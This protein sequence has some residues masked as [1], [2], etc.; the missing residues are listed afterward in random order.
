MGCESKAE[1]KRYNARPI[2]TRK[3]STRRWEKNNPE[4]HKAQL[5]RA[6]VRK[7]GLASDM[8]RIIA[9]AAQ[10]SAC[11]LCGTTK[12]DLAGSRMCIDHDHKTGKFRGLICEACNFGI[13]QC[14][15][16]PATLRAAA[17]YLESA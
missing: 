5:L 1:R 8:D 12:S 15:D 9:F 13:G 3:V 14:K 2:A 7:L 4:K 11:P 6:R 17:D 16:S 10:Y